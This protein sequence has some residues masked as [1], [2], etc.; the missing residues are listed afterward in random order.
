[1]I[2][3]EKG[4]D[5]SKSVHHLSTGESAQ[6]A[7]GLLYKGGS[8][9][10]SGSLVGLVAGWGRKGG[11]ALLSLL[12]GAHELPTSGEMCKPKPVVH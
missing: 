8:K 6:R 5:A 10:K 11:E 9:C 2:E 1:M 3:L 7:E 4:E 12:E